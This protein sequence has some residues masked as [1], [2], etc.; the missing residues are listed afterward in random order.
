MVVEK[1]DVTLTILKAK[2]LVAKDRAMLG[3]GKKTSSDPYIEVWL[4]S[5]H[6]KRCMG[7]TLTKYQT[8]EPEYK[9]TFQINIRGNEGGSILLKVFDEDKGSAPDAMGFVEIRIPVHKEIDEKK[10][11]D[12]PAESARNASGKILIKMKTKVHEQQS[13]T[14]DRIFGRPLTTMET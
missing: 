10:W 2:D 13:Y 14:L 9:Q 6:M 8:L 7:K 12:I 5:P 4:D 1:V 3:L 11:L